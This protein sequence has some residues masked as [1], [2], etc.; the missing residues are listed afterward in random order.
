[1]TTVWCLNLSVQSSQH[2]HVVAAEPGEDDV[3][4]GLEA[5]QASLCGAAGCCV[6][7]ALSGSTFLLSALRADSQAL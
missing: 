2:Q 3:H 7:S 6:G 5:L 1:M 4:P